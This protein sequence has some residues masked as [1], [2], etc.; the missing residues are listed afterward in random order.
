MVLLDSTPISNYE[1]N[2]YMKAAFTLTPAESKRLIAK[3]V[4]NSEEFKNASSNARVIVLSGTTNAYIAQELGI[5][6]R[7]ER[8]SAGISSKGVL[9]VTD[10]EQREKFPIVLDKGQRV[11]KTLTEAL[12]ENFQPGTLIIKGGNAID[13]E[14]NV[15]VIT[16]GF[17]GGNVARFIGTATSQGLKVMFAVGMEKTVAS[18]QESCKAAG[19]RTIDYSMGADFGMYFFPNPSK[20]TELDALRILTGVKA[21]HVA[22]GGFG[23]SE[24][25]V[26]LIAEGNKEEINNAIDLVSQIKGEPPMP[27]SKGDCKNSCRYFRC[28]YHGKENHELPQWLRN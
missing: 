22:S 28:A 24:G 15:G 5:D 26:T 23:G 8:S 2:S 11:E 6:V 18:V 10:P 17:D 25:A 13:S 9:C 27:S 19:A 7:P 4:I 1:R 12:E 14:G 20:V 21:I 16:A 3:G